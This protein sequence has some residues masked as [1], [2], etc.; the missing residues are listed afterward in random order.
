MATARPVM[1]ALVLAASTAGSLLL[2]DLC[3]RFYESHFLIHEVAPSATVYD[4]NAYHYSDHEGFLE[5]ARRE[6]EFRILSFG[7]SFAVSATLPE[8]SYAGVIQRNLST[9]TGSRRVRVVNFGRYGTSFPDYISQLRLWSAKVEFDAVLLNLYVG[10]D[11]SEPSGMLFVE[12]SP[13]EVRTRVSEGVLRYGPGVDVPT[14]YPLRFLDFVY[15]LYYSRAYAAPEHDDAKRYKPGAIHFPDDIYRQKLARHF[16]VYRPDLLES[17]FDAHYWLFKLMSLAAELEGRGVRVAVTV[18]PSH[19][20]VDEVLMEDALS[21]VGVRRDQIQV[22]L[23]ASAVG[24]LARRAGLGG[25]IFDLTACLRASE[26]LGEKPYWGT[27]THWSVSGNQ[28]VGDL[29]ADALSRRWLNGGYALEARPGDCSLDLPAARSYVEETL[30][31]SAAAI[32]ALLEFEQTTVAPLI[33]AQF[34]SRAALFTALE[35]LGY[36]RDPA[37]I[38]GSFNGFRPDRSDFSRPHG[39]ARALVPYGWAVDSAQAG[40]P[41]FVAF[42]HRGRLI[43][44][45]RTD[46]PAGLT[47]GTV[48]A[49]TPNAVFEAFI[50]SPTPSLRDPRKLWVIAIAPSGHFAPLP[51][52]DDMGESAQLETRAATR[53]D[54]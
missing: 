7:D 42:F 44:V 3:F 23:P 5:N 10:N 20:V 40:R 21:S 26:L 54:R 11:F 43:G 22:D 50:K 12:G 2:L 9:V 38:R 14:R 8:Y 15:V 27:N 32:E 29:V 6:G 28:L 18:A 52:R 13:D 36:Q 39:V 31:R 48:E 45:G 34:R 25:P 33:G 24:V 30:E 37:R 1:N 19:V 49:D 35:R 17:Y 41:L 16:D 47:M 53:D 4:L 46:E 51:Y